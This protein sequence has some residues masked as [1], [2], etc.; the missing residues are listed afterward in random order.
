MEEVVHRS[1]DRL[2][3]TVRRT[4]EGE[5]YHDEELGGAAVVHVIAVDFGP[6]AAPLSS[7]LAYTPR[8]AREMH[9]PLIRLRAKVRV[10]TED[11]GDNRRFLALTISDNSTDLLARAASAADPYTG[12]HRPAGQGI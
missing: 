3:N 10:N 12:R 5:M 8:P 7:D 1:A 11:A 2:P 9:Y 6:A 4:I